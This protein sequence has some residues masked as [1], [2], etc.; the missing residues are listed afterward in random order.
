V[1]N[2]RLLIAIVVLA[3]L[4]GALASQLRTHEASTSLE[5]PKLTLPELKRDEITKVEI[6]NPDKKLKVTLTKQ[7]K[8]WQLTAPLSAKADSAAAEAVLD[9]L[10][11]LKVAA[12]VA[13]HK[14]S[15]ARLKVDAAQAI[16]VKAFAGDK[17][18]LDVYVGET[19]ATGTMLR[20]E[21]EDAVVAVRGSIR[22]AFDKELKYLRDRVITDV[23]PATLKAA[24]LVSAKG[25]FKFETPEAGKWAQAKGEK[26]I[27]D[28]ADSKVDGLMLAFARLRADDFAEPGATPES[29]GLSAPQATL[30]LTPKEGAEIKLELG[31]LD[32]SQSNYFLRASGSP[33]LFRVAK[34]SGD[35][36]LA[37]AAAFSEPPKK[38]GEES[39][40]AP[41]GMPVAGGGDL[42]PEILKQLQQQGMMGGAHPPH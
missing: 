3:V 37:D 5:K 21:G 10:T 11:D 30:V 27:K 35:R 16:H 22:Y 36:L 24:S 23:D 31:Q 2:N 42:P 40:N 13:S 39:A 20:K 7:D 25:S 32:P 6:D 14:E 28:F 8:V 34:Y 4:A 17:A 38:P 19:K 41:R 29:T 15:H 18:L 12:S 1:N 33:V 9:K 26:P